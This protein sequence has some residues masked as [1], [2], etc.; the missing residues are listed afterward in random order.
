MAT[1]QV[2][3]DFPNQ[4]KETRKNIRDSFK[5]THEILQ[6]RESYLLSRIDEII[7]DYDNKMQELSENL[8][9]LA[10]LKSGSRKSKKKNTNKQMN[11]TID[12]KIEQLNADLERSIEFE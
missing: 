2:E 11:C 12:D 1:A 4:I 10:V 3:L 5:K 9:T 8:K 6:V 7:Q